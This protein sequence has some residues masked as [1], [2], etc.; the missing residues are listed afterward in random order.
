MAKLMRLG[1][2]E[3]AVMDHLWARGGPQ[4]VVRPATTVPTGTP[5]LMAMANW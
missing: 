3:R 2:L 5:Q 1:N 4:T